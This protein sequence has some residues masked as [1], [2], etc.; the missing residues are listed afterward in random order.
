LR[1]ASRPEP[2]IAA[3]QDRLGKA[4]RTLPR[5]W[6]RPG[7]CARQQHSQEIEGE[8][9]DQI[10]FRPHEKD[11]KSPIVNVFKLPSGRLVKKLVDEAP[12]VGLTFSPDGKA[13]VAHAW[14]HLRLA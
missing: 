8:I 1:G 14:A 2:G 3:I 7:P 12:V 5:D 9:V 4:L 10:E 11:T 6:R 13:G